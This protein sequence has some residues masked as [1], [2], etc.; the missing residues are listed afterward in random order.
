MLRSSKSGVGVQ[1]TRDENAPAGTRA[2]TDEAALGCDAGPAIR[3]SRTLLEHVCYTIYDNTTRRAIV[4]GRCGQGP[5]WRTRRREGP[6]PACRWR[7]PPAR[8]STRSW[9]RKGAPTPALHNV[10]LGYVTLSDPVPS[11]GFM[12]VLKSSVCA[13]L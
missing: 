11:V 9:S 12:R 8:C 1:R 3:T 5:R 2:A 4:P 6:C 13:K 10:I 7:A